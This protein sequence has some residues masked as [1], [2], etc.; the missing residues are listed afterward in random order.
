MG[1]VSTMEDQT[2][3]NRRELYDLKKVKAPNTQP[4][5]GRHRRGKLIP[6]KKGPQYLDLTTLQAHVE[7]L[8]DEEHRKLQSETNRA[9][10]LSKERLKRKI[11]DA[12]RTAMRKA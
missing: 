4:R 10:H 9:L 6:T 1:Y 12:Y 5:N 7:A 2:D 8:I 11:K 3:R